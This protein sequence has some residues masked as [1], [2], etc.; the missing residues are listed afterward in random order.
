MRINPAR[1]IIPGNTRASRGGYASVVVATL[2]PSSENSQPACGP[3]SSY[4]KREFLYQQVGQLDRQSR[5]SFRG[6]L[7]PSYQHVAVK[8]LSV[9]ENTDLD[10]LL[11]VRNIQ[12]A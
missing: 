11:R 6:Y 5:I 3:G 4:D 8:K 12:D 2:L 1:L 7:H 10:G 9:R